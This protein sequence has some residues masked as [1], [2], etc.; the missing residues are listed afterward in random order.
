MHEG[1]YMRSRSSVGCSDR[2]QE[3]MLS[4]KGCFFLQMIVSHRHLKDI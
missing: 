1:K 4:T 2:G 3:N